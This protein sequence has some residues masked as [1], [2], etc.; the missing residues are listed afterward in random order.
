MVI[1]GVGASAGGLEAFTQMLRACRRSRLGVRLRAAPVAASRERAGAL[2][3]SQ[4][5]MPV[6]QA[7]EGM[8]VEAGPRLRD[9]AERADGDARRRAAPDAAPDDRYRATRRSTPSSR[10]WPRRRS[11]RGDRRDP[12]G[13]RAPTAPLGL[14]DVKAR[15][16]H[17]LRAVAGLGEVR[18]HA[19]RRHRHRDGR[20]G[21]AAGG[22]SAPSWRE[23]GARIRTCGDRR[24]PTMHDVGDDQLQRIFDV[25]QA[26]Q[27]R[28]LQALQAADHQAAAVP[29]HGAAPDRPTSA[30]TSQLLAEQTQRSAQPLPGS[31]D[32]RHP[33]LPRAGVVRGLAAQVFPRAARGPPAGA[34]DPRLGV[35]VRHRRGSLLARDRAARVPAERASADT[36]V[37][38]FATDVSESAIEHARAGVYPASIEA[39]VSPSGC[40]A[41]SRAADGG[42]RVS[43][44]VRDLCVFARQDLTKDPPFSQLDLIML[45][46]RPDLHGRGAAAEAARRCSTT[47]ST[48]AASWCSARPRAW[49]RRRSLFAL[50][51]KKLR[52]HRKKDGAGRADR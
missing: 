11:E 12:V 51:D 48:R 17:H 3:T 15:R 35:A 38:I 26:G 22:R 52:I 37:Q 10:R 29:A 50:V 32:P 41:S 24:P 28:R 8:R 1:V 33:V 16:R 47:R 36:R 18:R 45:P 25:L 23:L 7:T 5:P 9:P 19:A 4:T 2:L 40:G 39:D 20:P 14:R 21:A 43:K 42:Y 46:Q 30:T 13:H 44:M 34:A 27:R 31:A 49:A 6:V